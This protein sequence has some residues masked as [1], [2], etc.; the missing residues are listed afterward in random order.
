MV[1]PPSGTGREQILECCGVGFR[2][3]RGTLGITQAKR[4]VSREGRRENLGAQSVQMGVE[5]WSVPGQ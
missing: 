3:F 2:V 5:S 4:K 1:T